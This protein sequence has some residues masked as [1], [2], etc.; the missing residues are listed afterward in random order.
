M[1]RTLLTVLSV[2]LVL[3]SLFGIFASFT[4][5][6]DVEAIKLEKAAQRGN[7]LDAIQL[8]EDSVTELEA[9]AE[10]RSDDERNFA[11]GTAASQVGGKQIS[12][13]QAQYDAG[14]RQLEQ[15]KAQYAAGEKSYADAQALYES[16]QAEY[17]AAQ[18][19]LAEAKAQ[20]AEA[21]QLRDQ[22]QAKLDRAAPLYN[23]YAKGNQYTGGVLSGVGVPIADTL[24]KDNLAKY[25]FGTLGE[26]ISTYEQGQSELASANAQI[27]DAEQQIADGEK[28]LAAAKQQLDAG[29]K[30]LDSSRSQLDNAKRDIAAGESKLNS[31][32]GQLAQSKAQ[33]QQKSNAMADALEGLK[34]YDDAQ[35]LVDAGMEVILANSD[36]AEKITDPEDYR[37]ALNV[38]RAYIDEDEVNVQAELDARHSLYSL[39]RIVSIIALAAGIVCCIAALNPSLNK[40]KAAFI[41]AAAASAFA[42][43]LY[44]FSAV[45]GSRFFVYSLANG[46]GSG[47]VQ[48]TAIIVLLIA[49]VVCAVLAA[50]CTRA[51]KVGLGL[52]APKEKPQRK[53][54][55]TD[56]DD[57]D[58]P[59]YEEAV[60]MGI[61]PAELGTDAEDSIELPEEEEAPRPTR[62]EQKAMKAAEEAAATAAAVAAA[63]EV[64]AEIAEKERKLKEENDLLKAD[65]EQMEFEKARREYEAARKKYEEARRNANK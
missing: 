39:L 50:L 5:L 63:A 13:G 14:K 36:I 58:A 20:L 38:T 44:I 11:E 18:A 22:G 6:D 29:K 64:S 16:K 51:Y 31:A 24:L 34:Q 25:G 15:G 21:K 10:E 1:K 37:G 62:R 12:Q 30:Q 26:A 28:Q 19:Q 60:E 4:G 48:N 46:N 32:A 41:S 27:A 23:I 9:M 7:L 3:A 52:A 42:L 35:A 43:A 40:L 33:V 8:M 59:F 57:N 45:K 55:D 49:A 17:E 47:I 2:I 54:V 53:I 61:T 65:I 56:K